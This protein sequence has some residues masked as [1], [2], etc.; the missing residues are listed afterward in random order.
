MSAEEAALTWVLMELAKQKIIIAMIQGA[1]ICF[2]I[3]RTNV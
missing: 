1:F 3:S 2:S